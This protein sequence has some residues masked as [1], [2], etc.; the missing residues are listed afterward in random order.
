MSGPERPRP[1]NRALLVCVS[2]YAREGPH[3]W[4]DVLGD[5]AAAERNLTVLEGVLRA[6]G[7]F[8][9]VVLLSSPDIREFEQRL[10]EVRDSTDGLLLVYFAGHGIVDTCTGEHSRLLLGLGGAK[11][12]HGPAFPGW[13]HWEDKV[14]HRLRAGEHRPRHTVV[15]LDCCYAGNAA[16]AWD[17]LEPHDQRR[18]SL[19]LAVQRNQRIDAGD[20]A[21]PTPYTALLAEAL[22]PGRGAPEGD[23]TVEV[24]H[25]R[26]VDGLRAARTV[27]GKEWL[28]QRRWQDTGEKVVLLPERA[29]VPDPAPDPGPVPPWWHRPLPPGPRRRLIAAALAVPAAL[30]LLLWWIASGTSDGPGPSPSCAHH[31][32]LELRLL[33]D[34]DLA[35]A[36]RRAADGFVASGANRDGDGCRR[37]G[38]TVY[39]AGSA[40][41]V[42]A[43]R[44]QYG[45]WARG[46]SSGF[47]PVGSVGPQPDVWIPASSAS[48][49]RAQDET[50][51]QQSVLSLE[52]DDGRPLARTPL[53]LLVPEPLAEP[54]GDRAG[55]RLA[56]L[57]KAITGKAKGAEFRR[58]DPR[59]TDAGLAAT[60]GLYRVDA[61]RAVEERQRSAARSSGRV[62]GRD[63]VCGLARGDRDADRR[64]AVL[65]AAPVLGQYRG[66]AGRTG[67]ARV[68]E[69][70]DDVPALDPV[71]VHVRWNDARRD[72]DERDRAVRRFGDWL[73]S[74][75]GRAVFREEGLRPVAAPSSSSGPSPSPGPSAETG[76]SAATGPLPRPLSAGEAADT[77]E[78]YR[79][80]NAAGRVR[81]L[82]DSSGSMNRW[83]DGANGAREIV[84]RAMTRFGPEDS[85]GVWGVAS[86]GTGPPYRELLPFGTH[87][88]SS[89]TAGKDDRDKATAAAGKVDA[90]VP[91]PSLE[92]DVGGALRAA[93]DGMPHGTEDDGHPQLV[94]LLTDDE[95]ND[96]LDAARRD[97]LVKFVADRKVPV[98]MV[99]FDSGGCLEGRLDLRVAEASGGRCLDSRGDLAGDLA[100]EVAKVA[101]GH[102]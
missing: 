28:P 13:I 6:G 101:Q 12:E 20:S 11:V 45:E 74:E 77:L 60:A 88:S 85:Y 82:L 9:E 16:A 34:P 78:K 26:L 18:I 99:S 38:V 21:T 54:E 51:N 67:V 90:A 30:A 25:R 72:E 92:A 68:A 8:A 44:T 76:P 56:E 80:A 65:V 10:G 79:Q 66:C 40:D 94:I 98:V 53:A 37:T 48:A 102:G 81:F 55:R 97:E 35:P 57:T 91:A 64:T 49:R 46:S 86:E 7:V 32:P 14:L 69:Y 75:D 63:L 84:E 89:R 93:L 73:A 15:V 4:A 24:L 2:R 1:V 96:R 5:I 47:N 3:E 62:G 58:A 59:Y 42:E 29:P 41:T 22:T 87:G 61:P 100:G 52:F 71:F 43:F 33:T 36:V 27:A 39:S 19:L 95:D 83:W 31:P 23:V 17:R 70:P 50:S